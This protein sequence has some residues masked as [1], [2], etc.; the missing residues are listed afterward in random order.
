VFL[1]VE[2]LALR[3]DTIVTLLAILVIAIA[4][5]FAI[6]DTFEQGRVY[7]FSRQFLEELPQRF[8]GP[9]R[10]RFILQPMISIIVGIRG[11]LADAKAGILPTYSVCFSMQDVEAN[12]CEAEQPRSACC[13]PWGSSWTSSFSWSSTGQFIQAQPCWLG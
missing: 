8:T 9:G 1:E 13:L 6:V 11:G 12:C 10:F 2:K 3:R 4:L 5:P 7:I